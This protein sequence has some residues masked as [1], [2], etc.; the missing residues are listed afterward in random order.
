MA[1]EGVFLACLRRADAAQGAA[2]GTAFVRLHPATAR[3]LWRR[4]V[5]DALGANSTVPPDN[6]DDNV[7]RITSETGASPHVASGIEFLPLQL[8]GTE[9]EDDDD[10]TTTTSATVYAS[11]N[12]GEIAP[13][14]FRVEFVACGIT[15]QGRLMSEYSIKPTEVTMSREIHCCLPTEACPFHEPTCDKAQDSQPFS[16]SIYLHVLLYHY[17]KR[18]TSARRIVP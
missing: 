3:A 1:A 7:W 2:A 5:D 10:T 13:G 11:Y 17:R 8:D 6:N 15:N 9:E 12:G 18:G 16:L 14:R 4:A